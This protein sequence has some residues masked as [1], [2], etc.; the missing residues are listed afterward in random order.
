MPKK[1][2]IKTPEEI[3]AKIAEI[4]KGF[5]HVLTGSTATVFINAPR[6]LE[7]IAAETKLQTLHWMLGT[8]YKSKLKGVDR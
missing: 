8:K 6:A 5:S 2:P 7:Q 3:K 1:I 4:E